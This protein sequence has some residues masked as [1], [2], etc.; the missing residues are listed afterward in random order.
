MKKLEQHL[1]KIDGR[2]YKAYKEIQGR[3]QFQNY[4]LAVDYVQGDPFASPS[5]IRLIIPREKLKID[6]KALRSKQ[7][8]IRTDDFLTRIIAKAIR[9]TQSVRGTG[10]SGLIMIDTPG[11]EVLERT[12]VDVGERFVTVCLSVGLPAQGRRVLG[13]QAEILFFK[14]IPAIMADSVFSLDADKLEQSLKLADQQEAIRAF[15]K[16]NDY[17]SFIVNGSILPRESGI[18]DKPLNR[19]KVV[20]FQA[21][22][23]MEKAITVPHQD[24]PIKGMVVESGISLIVGGGYH[25]KSTLLHAIERGVYDHIEGDGREFVLTDDRAFKVR[26]EDGRQV[27]NVDISPF[28][29]NLPYGKDT[30]RFKTEN[31]SGSTS[32]AANIMEA[33]EVGASSLLIDEDTSAS[34]FMIRDARMQALVA[35]EK[36]PITP[37]IDR[38]R[39]LYEE[40]GISSIIVMGGSGD[41]FDVADRVIMME[42]YVPYDKTEKAKNIAQDIRFDRQQE[43]GDRFGSIT[44]RVPLKGS[45]NSQKGKKSKVAARGKHAI[46]Y[47]R[48]DINLQFIEQLVDDSQTRMIA[49]ILHHLERENVLAKHLTVKKLVALIENK[50]NEQGLGSFTVF[51]NQHPGELARPRGLEIA[52]ALNRIRTMQVR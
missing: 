40:Y 4:V 45:L 16:E 34:N 29:N 35:K 18:S 42:Q 52:A 24:E 41:Y 9:K 39:Q 38:V 21:P 20:P 5:K 11:Q 3:Y 36:E 46:Q 27:T 47:G 26:A 7:R 50:M 32:Q 43:G 31:A 25:G 44:E 19:G 14:Q 48:T 51:S 30:I 37:F 2:G 49:E 1:K 13:K 8:K 12:A 23:E 33:V 17:I 22:K 15:L 28:I 10:K 6:S